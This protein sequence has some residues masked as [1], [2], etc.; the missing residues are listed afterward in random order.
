MP[1]QALEV[2]DQHD[3]STVTGQE[4]NKSDDGGVDSRAWRME[5]FLWDPRLI[6]RHAHA[7]SRSLSSGCVP[8]SLCVSPTFAFYLL[9]GH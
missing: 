2:E 7:S 1:L 8:V 3:P 9:C 6:A 4:D 5:D